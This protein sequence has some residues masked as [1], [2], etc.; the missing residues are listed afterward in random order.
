MGKIKRIAILTGGGD[1]PGLNN[2]MKQVVYR[3]HKAGIEVIGIRRGWGGLVNYR[4]GGDP[5]WND[6]WVTTLE[7]I[8]VRTI[9]RTGGTFLHTSRTNPAKMREQDLPDHLQS[10]HCCRHSGCVGYCPPR[11]CQ[12]IN[13]IRCMFRNVTCFQ[14]TEFLFCEVMILS[15]GANISTK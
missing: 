10:V 8:H 6:R 12:V 2:A 14:F 3:A 13:I 15:S 4:I 7:G 1:V 5:D 9:D 11:D